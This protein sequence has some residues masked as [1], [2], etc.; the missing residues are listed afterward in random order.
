MVE[1]KSIGIPTEPYEVKTKILWNSSVEEIKEYAQANPKTFVFTF[2]T[3]SVED[4]IDYSALLM[5]ADECDEW[6]RRVVTPMYI[7]NVGNPEELT[8]L[9]VEQFLMPWEFGDYK[10]WRLKNESF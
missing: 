6:K 1:I 2:L 10:I 7:G 3:G 4:V 9:T 8:K 5:S